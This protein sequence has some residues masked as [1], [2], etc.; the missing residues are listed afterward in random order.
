MGNATKSAAYEEL[1]RTLISDVRNDVSDITG[2]DYSRLP[3][4]FGLP[5]WNTASGT[6]PTYQDRV[7]NSMMT[8]A[9]DPTLLNVSCVD[10]KGLTQHDSWHFDAAGQKYLGESFIN[11]LSKLNE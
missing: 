8:V 6:A 9:N 5:S 3:F 10:T 1:L 4:V 7:R 2:S 11:E